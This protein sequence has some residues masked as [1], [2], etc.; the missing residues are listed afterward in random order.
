MLKQI[1]EGCLY[2]R[3]QQIIHRDIK[4]SNIFLKSGVPVLADFGFAVY[5]NDN[6]LMKIN[7]GSPLYMPK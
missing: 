1:V 7:A 6:N 3:S 2:L 4:L 5:E